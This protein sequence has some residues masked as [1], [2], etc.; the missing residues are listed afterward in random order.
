MTIIEELKQVQTEWGLYDF[1]MCNWMCV[2][3]RRFNEIMR[4]NEMPSIYNLIMFVASTR[5]PLYSLMP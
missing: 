3:M 4:G 2:S 1:E 5:R